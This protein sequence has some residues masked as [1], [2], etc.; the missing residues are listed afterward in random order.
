MY[1]SQTLF[2]AAITFDKDLVILFQV[3]QNQ[4]C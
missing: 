1:I 4:L 3:P 2:F